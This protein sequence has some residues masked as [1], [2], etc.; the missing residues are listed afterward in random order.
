MKFCIATI[1]FFEEHGFDTSE[2]RKSLDGTVT[3]LHLPMA[4]TLIPDIESDP[5]VQIYV[6]PS[7]ELSDLLSSSEWKDKNAI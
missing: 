5:N 3:M 1:Q 7:Q 4:Q 6:A 2:W